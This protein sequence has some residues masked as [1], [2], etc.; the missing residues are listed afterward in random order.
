[1]LAHLE[2]PEGGTDADHVDDAVLRGVVDVDGGLDPHVDQHEDVGQQVAQQRAHREDGAPVARCQG[3]LNIH[4]CAQSV[5]QSVSHYH[6]TGQEQEGLSTP[7][8]AGIT[9]AV[10]RSS[11]D[12]AI[13]ECR[14]KCWDIYWDTRC[15][16]A[17]QF[18]RQAA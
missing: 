12:V 13:L 9:Q 14:L 2:E 17:T 7:R 4:L 10:Q 15:G 1:M 6:S 5:S 18:K 3:H 11:F 16:R 8:F